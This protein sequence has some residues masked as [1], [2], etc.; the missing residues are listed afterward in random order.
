MNGINH[1]DVFMIVI[2]GKFVHYVRPAKIGSLKVKLT[3]IFGP[4]NPNT[5]ADGRSYSHCKCPCLYP[6]GKRFPLRPQGVHC[7]GKSQSRLANVG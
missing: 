7:Y 6:S 5:A 4:L 2:R 3:F 1:T